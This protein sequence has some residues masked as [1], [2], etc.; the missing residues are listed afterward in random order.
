MS[1]DY[2]VIS[3][4]AMSHNKL[5]GEAAPVRTSHATSTLVSYGKRLILVDPSLPAPALDARFNERTGKRL[6]DVT[7]IFCTTLRPVHR[8]SIESMPHADW[9]CSETELE[10][11]R[12][13]LEMLHDSA[14]RLSKEDEET[15]HR[16][17][18]LVNRFKAAP[19]K[20]GPQVQLYPLFG[21]SAGSAGLLVASATTTTII[22]GD[23]AITAG[24]VL[25]GQV[26]QGCFDATAALETLEDLL[27]VA[28]I[29]V[30]GHDNMMVVPQRM[31]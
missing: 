10:G 12:N 23:A 14:S 20:F 5:W 25:A 22:A 28:D 2:T 27:Q 11:Y 17:L 30:C 29:I 4:G 21:A 31:L 15:I 7:D 26:W 24:H 13:H 3:I 19:E 1:V 6:A 18:A 16:D 9:W 8:R